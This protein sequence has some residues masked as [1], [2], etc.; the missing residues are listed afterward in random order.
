ML[1]DEH[2]FSLNTIIF[3][4]PLLL[5][6]FLS[7]LLCS[8]MLY[9]RVVANGFKVFIGLERRLGA[10]LPYGRLT[11]RRLSHLPS[12]VLDLISS[13][14]KFPNCIY[15]PITLSNHVIG[16]SCCKMKQIFSQLYWSTNC[17]ALRSRAFCM[18]K[19]L[20]LLEYLIINNMITDY[21]QN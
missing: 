17:L 15:Y 12:A 20:I 13:S 11:G 16:A 4:V 6:Y 19:V 7:L 2:L 3:T 14:R 18:Y 10:S 8:R 5:F 21:D 9:G 1:W